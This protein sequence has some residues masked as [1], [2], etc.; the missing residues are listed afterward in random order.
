[1]KAADTTTRIPA[2]NLYIECLFK[3]V[4]WPLRSVI[5][6]TIRP[7]PLQ[8]ALAERPHNSTAD[9]DEGLNT[10]ALDYTL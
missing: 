10:T 7:I 3:S 4:D 1:M 6:A 5:D 9:G 8:S 2:S